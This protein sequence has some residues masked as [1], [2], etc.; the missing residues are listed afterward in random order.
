MWHCYGN[1]FELITKWYS[2]VMYIVY[3]Y[4]YLLLLVLVFLKCRLIC[5]I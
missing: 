4:C 5:V 3:V 2:M 1:A